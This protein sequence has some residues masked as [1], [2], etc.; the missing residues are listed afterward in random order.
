MPRYRRLCRH[1]HE[2][3]PQAFA[4]LLLEVASDHAIEGAIMTK[5]ET[6]SQMSPELIDAVAGRDW[7]P[8]VLDEVGR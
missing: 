2:L 7:P 1:V 6:L 4:A 5:L 3:G 8:T